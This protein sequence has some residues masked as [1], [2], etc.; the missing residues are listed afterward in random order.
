VLPGPGQINAGQIEMH[1]N[2]LQLV[3]DELDLHQKALDAFLK[4]GMER[5]LA[6]DWFARMTLV[7]GVPRT[8]LNVALAADLEHEETEAQ[9][10]RLEIAKLRSQKEILE[11]FLEE[12]DKAVKVPQKGKVQLT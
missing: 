7:Q 12:A 4:A 1:R 3:T 11:K 2:G 10:K 6:W 9:L 8:Q 5:R